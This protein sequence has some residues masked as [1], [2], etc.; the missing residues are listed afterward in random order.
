MALRYGLVVY[1]RLAL[2]PHPSYLSLLSVG[3][4]GMSY[5][6]RLKILPETTSITDTL[7]LL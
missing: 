6:A 5:S 7:W 3:V 1:H 2:N 4:T